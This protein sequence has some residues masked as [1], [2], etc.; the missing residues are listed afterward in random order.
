MTEAEKILMNLSPEEREAVLTIL[1]E[2]ANSGASQ[3]LADLYS[4]DYD[5]IPVDIDTFLESPTYL[6]NSTNNGTA[7]YP[8][9]RNAYR[10]IINNDK[11]E[12][13]F[14]GS[15]GCG[16]ACSL[17]SNLVGPNG[18][19]KMRDVKVGDLVAGQDGKFYHVTSI[20]PQGKI[21]IYR[22]TFSDH[23]YVECSID[24]LW[25]I[26]R[27]DRE[28]KKQPYPNASYVYETKSVRWLLQQDLKIGRGRVDK[29]GHK[30]EQNRFAIPVTLPVQFKNDYDFVIPPYVMGIL[31]ADG[32]LSTDSVEVSIYEED[33]KDRVN[34][35]LAPIG[36][37]LKLSSPSDKYEGLGDFSIN[38]KTYGYNPVIREIKK[39]NLNVKSV[40]KHIPKEY[41]LSSVENR[42]EL[43]RGLVDGDGYIEPARYMYSTSSK[44]LYEDFCF[45]IYSLGG[46]VNVTEGK[47]AYRYLPDGTKKKSEYL[48]YEFTFH[49]PKAIRAFHSDKHTQRFGKGTMYH[50]MEYRFIE[51]IEPAG[52]AECQ[53]ITVDNPE[54]LYLMD[55]FTVTHNTTAAIYLM[56]YFVYKLMCLKNIR[57]Y[58]GLE[59]N[60]PVCIAFLNN[61]IQLSKGVA[62][63]KFMST[64]STSP[65]FLERGEVRGT[66]NIRYKPHKNIEFVLGSSADQI[67]G[68][69]IFCLTGDTK[70][71][72][73]NGTFTIGSIENKEVYVETVDNNGNITYSDKPCIIKRTKT[74]AAVRIITLST[75]ET[76]RCTYNHKFLMVDMTYKEAKDLK[77]QDKLF[78]PTDSKGIEVIN[79][80]MAAYDQK[81]PVY[82]VINSEPYHNFV[83]DAGNGTLVVSHNCAI[84]DEV[85]FSKGSDIHFEKN[86]VLETYNA[87]FGRIKNR[88]TINGKCQGRIFLV[89]SKKTE[90]DFLNQY[91]ERKMKSSEDA[92]NL[93]VADAKAF[94]VKPKGSYSGKMFR[95]AV[96]GS[97][98]PSKIPT[99]DETNEDLIHQG[100]EIYDVPVELKGDFELDINRFIADHLGISVS[101]VIKFI[102]YNKVEACY[103]DIQNPVVMEVLKA[104]LSD[105]VSIE[106]YFRPQVVPESVYTKPIFIH[107]DTSGGRGDNCGISG[108][109]RMGYVY[110]NRYS[111]ETGNEET[112]KQMLYRHVFSLGANADKHTELSFQK[113][114]DFLWYLKYKLHWNIFAVSTDGYMGQFLRQQI[115][116]AGFDRVDYVSL[117]RSPDGYL[118]FQSI[119]AE[120]RIALIKLNLL[121]SEIVRL[122]RNNISGKIDHPL[123]GCFTG[124]TGILMPSGAVLTILELKEL[125]ERGIVNYVKS[126]NE[127]TLDEEL[128]EISKV[129]FTKKSIIA[130]IALS[131]G[132]VIR[133]TPDHRFLLKDGTY[134]KAQYLKP[135]DDLMSVY[136]GEVFVDRVVITD[137]MG[138]V[139]DISVNGTPNFALAAGVYAHNSKDIADSLAGALYNSIL[140]EKDIPEAMDDLLETAA[141]VNTPTPSPIKYKIQEQSTVT[142]EDVNKILEDLKANNSHLNQKNANIIARRQA[143]LDSQTDEVKENYEDMDDGF[144][145]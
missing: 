113:V 26:R 88:F 66:V 99:D 132:S 138:D 92:K 27:T 93:F 131:N 4:D 111:A 110:R 35:L 142:A 80:T 39:L 52:E 140:H 105:D 118:A 16:K 130:K 74:V 102:P 109:A 108:V 59:G 58:F 121:E 95:V 123:D 37:Y 126:C 71:K 11:V 50:E 13:A 49:M 48:N 104:N 8:Y 78:T 67:I 125:Y 112:T 18:Y 82:D 36:C 135:S 124:D 136:Q 139:Y 117:D 15:I 25:N 2:Q 81:I 63:D 101:E 41:L 116:A 31:L 65:W 73:K 114:V 55:N 6:G 53:C 85:N 94:E 1:K 23:T 128:N 17:D 7:I 133:C 56:S 145:I 24:H 84:Q 127:D 119:L 76:I 28:S 64:V 61:T 44:Q 137:K 51:S 89:S 12:C 62:Y 42:I 21:P 107:I 141:D 5:E 69:D 90:Y 134:K 60:G 75:K 129:F 34:E 33:I 20:W 86:K 77:P 46:T 143:F 122:E 72:T 100:Y 106:S 70:I 54:S 30:L 43:L 91:I 57:Q 96:G 14:S 79:V 103:K 83:V 10:E 45:L 120:E 19:F 115:S 32:G 22:I 9:W 144:L 3:S 87:C 97:N 68:R 98:L 47:E 38:S 29:K 40:D